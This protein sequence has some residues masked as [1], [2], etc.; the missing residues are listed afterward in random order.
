M[1]AYPAK[2]VRD[3]K[4]WLVTFRDVPEA[5]TSGASREEAIEL[6]ADALRTAMEFY[7]ED[8]RETPVPS[9]AAEVLIELPFDVS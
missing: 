2:L 6:A 9:Q 5:I 7:I 4:A 8:G 1:P 3:G